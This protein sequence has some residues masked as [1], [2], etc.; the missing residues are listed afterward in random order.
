MNDDKLQTMA[1]T[2]DPQIFGESVSPKAFGIA[3]QDS[4]MESQ[5]TY[6]VLFE[7]QAKYNAIMHALG[8]IIYREMRDN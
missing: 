2:T 6:T 7:D 8:S 5:D 1:K 4:Y 3:A